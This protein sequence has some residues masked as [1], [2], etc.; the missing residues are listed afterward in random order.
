YRCPGKALNINTKNHPEGWSLYVADDSLL[1]LAGQCGCQVVI[2]GAFGHAGP[3]HTAVA[4]AHVAVVALLEAGVAVAEFFED[5]VGSLERGV[6]DVAREGAQ[7]RAGDDQTGQGVSVVSVV[8][9]DHLATGRTRSHVEQ[10]L[11]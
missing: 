3:R 4:E 2:E 6:H 10:A 7:H 11:I 8:I 9:A 1:A 5:F